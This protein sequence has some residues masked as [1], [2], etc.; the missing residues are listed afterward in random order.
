MRPYPFKLS[1]VIEQANVPEQ[2]SQLVAAYEPFVVR[3]M[4]ERWPLH[5]QLADAEG[6][7]ARIQRLENPFVRHTDSVHLHRA[8][9]SGRHRH[10]PR[11]SRQTFAWMIG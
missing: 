8:G 2:L 9:P 6:L 1:A 3:G 10:R 7:G 11:T 5:A 4:A